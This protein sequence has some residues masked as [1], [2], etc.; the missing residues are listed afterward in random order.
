MG[1]A[2]VNVQQHPSGDRRIDNESVTGHVDGTVYRQRVEIA[3]ASLAEVAA[4]NNSGPASDAYGLVTRSTPAA[5]SYD[6]WLN[7]YLTSDGA[8][9]AASS[10]QA[11]VDG[12]ITPVRFWRGPGAGVK[13][14]VTRLVVSIKDTGTFDADKYGNGATLT[15]GVGVEIWDGSSQLLDILD[16]VAVKT[17]MHCS[18]AT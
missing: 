17:N 18:T 10:E 16:G 5:V 15:N 6:R 14:V 12:S 3:G 8:A 13:W 7:L 2:S 11:N 9:P 1:D 4:V